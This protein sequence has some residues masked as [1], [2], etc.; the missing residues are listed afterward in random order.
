M[1]SPCYLSR[2]YQSSS[3]MVLKVESI[4]KRE[5]GNSNFAFW[6]RKPQ[7]E[8]HLLWLLISLKICHINT[9][10]PT[11]FQTL[12]KRFE[13]M[14]Q[15]LWIFIVSTRGLQGSLSARRWRAQDLPDKDTSD[16]SPSSQGGMRDPVISKY[17]NTSIY[18][19]VLYWSI[20]FISTPL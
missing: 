11:W 17:I 12:G 20:K 14:E 7:L 19:W 9:M 18:Y 10:T 5:G 2:A 1:I 8:D 13:T 3:I 15:F 16:L 4:D 6:R